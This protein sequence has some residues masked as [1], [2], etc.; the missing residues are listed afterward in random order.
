M[1][2]SKNWFFW[3]IVLVKTLE[4]PFDS[5]EIKP[6]NPKGNP[7]WI[8]IGRTD[9]AAETPILW[10]PDVKTW[11]IGKDPYA[12][13]EW[14]LEEKGTRR[15]RWLYGTTNSIDMS[16]SRLWEMLM[17]RE[18]WRAAVHGVT[19]SWT[20]WATELNAYRIT[21]KAIVLIQNFYD[22]KKENWVNT[23]YS[24]FLLF[25]PQV[26]MKCLQHTRY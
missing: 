24:P 17:D 16:L 12:G 9:A 3:I 14:R 21:S 7:P 10:P 22:L 18:A 2:V 15:M 13:K 6:D 4:D 23:I 26:D 19:K 20:H 11:L 8:F 25:I 1:F 5:K